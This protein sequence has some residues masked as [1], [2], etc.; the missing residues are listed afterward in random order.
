MR[1]FLPVFLLLFVAS[2]SSQTEDMIPPMPTPEAANSTLRARVY[3]ENSGRPVRRT[4]VLLM[5]ANEGPRE[6]A[7][8]TDA[9]G[10]LVIK[11]LRAGKYYAI[12]NSPGAVSPLAFIDFRRPRM[13]SMEEQLAPFPAIIVNGISDVDTV[14]QVKMGGAISGR[15]SYADGGPAIGVKVEVL[16]KVED[17]FLPTLPNFS[18]LSQAAS[19]GAGTFR[20]DD[21]GQYRVAGLPPGEYIVKVSEEMVHSTGPDS[22]NRMGFDAMLFGSA[23]LVSVFFNDA[24]DLENAQKLVIDAGQEYAETNIVIPER[25]LHVLEGKLV[26]AKDKLPI[27]GARMSVTLVGDTPNVFEGSRGDRLS[28]VAYTD[29]KGDWKFID[30]PKGKYKV[31]AQPVNSDYDE[32]QKAYGTGRSAANAMA[33]AA[34]AIANVVS[35]NARTGEKPPPPKFSKKTSE[36]KIDDKDLS[37]QVIELSFGATMRGTVTVE[38]NDNFSES[39]TI[40]ASDDENSLTS[41]AS[42]YPYDYD[43]ETGQRKPVKAKEFTI[44]AVSS[45]KTY[46]TVNASS[47]DLYVKSAFSGQV[48]LLKGPIELKDGEVLSNVKIVLAA[49]SGELEGTMVDGDDRP[50][51]GFDLTFVPTDPAKYK[52]S[53]LYRSARSDVNGEFKVKLPPFEYAVVLLPKSYAKESRTNFHNWLAGAVKTAQTFKIDPGKTTKTKIV[54]KKERQ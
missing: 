36:F 13:E 37:G 44:E 39:L 20:T 11:N 18:V 34:N 29:E 8:L 38:G 12:V 50:V 21:R 22:S 3:Y 49:D 19:G 53:S 25:P 27:R 32:G 42:I 6:I 17:E 9:A 14:I 2:V 26:S 41:S 16:R 31:T 15:V 33:N 35:G 47:K 4:N 54:S 10:N 51:S 52:N 30:L 46:L 28:H 24:Y 1:I 23:S 40:T 45:G 43:D 48:D 5:S 7:G